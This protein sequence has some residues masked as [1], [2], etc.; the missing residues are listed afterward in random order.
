MGGHKD[1]VYKKALEAAWRL[2][3]IYV[4]KGPY[5]LYPDKLRVKSIIEGLANN[6]MLHGK[7]YCPCA[8][9]EESMKKG[10]QMV[11]PCVSHHEDIKR[12]GYCDCALFVSR[13]FIQKE[14]NNK[15]D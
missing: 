13:E 8:T 5:K 6:K 2:V 12:Q 15:K 4:E 1:R 9:V 14:I 3:N 7:F 10:G 11:C